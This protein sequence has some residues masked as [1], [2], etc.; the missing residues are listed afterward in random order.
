MFTHTRRCRTTLNLNFCMASFAE[1]HEEYFIKAVNLLPLLRD[2]N[3]V[4]SQQFNNTNI[5]VPDLHREVYD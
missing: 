3:Q 4:H 2:I 5:P 1:T